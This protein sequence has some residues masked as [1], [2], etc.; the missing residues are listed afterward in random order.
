MRAMNKRMAEIASAADPSKLEA[1]RFLVDQVYTSIQLPFL[2]ATSSVNRSAHKWSTRYTHPSSF[3]SQMQPRPIIQAPINA[4]F[5][6][7]WTCVCTYAQVSEQ[8]KA[9]RMQ[10]EHTMQLEARMLELKRENEYMRQTLTG[11]GADQGGEWQGEALRRLQD[12]VS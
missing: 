2:D 10:K 3:H 9:M 6:H 7:E 5:F 8:E 1:A 12:Q 11:L 4:I